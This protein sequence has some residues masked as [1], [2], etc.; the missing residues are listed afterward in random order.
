M[1]VI[2]TIDVDIIRKAALSVKAFEKVAE[3]KDFSNFLAPASELSSNAVQLVKMATNNGMVDTAATI[4]DTVRKA[5]EA[6]KVVLKE[7]SD[8]SL[9]N[10]VRLLGDVARVIVQFMNEV[11]AKSAPAGMYFNKILIYGNH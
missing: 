5:M 11:K 1:S 4:R 9:E 2:G 6:A 7:K 3:V 8:S 10:F